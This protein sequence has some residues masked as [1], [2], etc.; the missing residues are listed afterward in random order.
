MS[1]VHDKEKSLK[2]STQFHSKFRKEEREEGGKEGGK[3][4][5]RREKT[6]WQL[7]APFYLQCNW[8]IS[9]MSFT[10]VM[11]ENFLQRLSRDLLTPSSN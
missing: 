3:E 1:E 8:V 4:G 7:K 6:P 10:T 5:E 11:K 2:D 9:L